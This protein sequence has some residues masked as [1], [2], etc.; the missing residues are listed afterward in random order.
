MKTFCILFTALLLSTQAFAAAG[1]ISAKN[2]ETRVV[3]SLYDYKKVSVRME[4]MNYAEP[5][6]IFI[7]Y[8]ALDFSG[9]EL[10][11]G[12]FVDT[13]QKF[14]TKYLTETTMIENGVYNKIHK[15][16]IGEID[17]YPAR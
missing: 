13:L 15:W 10:A 3:Q 11:S 5:V 14:D 7:K 8:R 16:E 12:T 2:I 9:Y 1:D 4:V 17:A 6:K